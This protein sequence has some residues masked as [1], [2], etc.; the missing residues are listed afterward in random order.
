M[1]SYAQKGLTVHHIEIKGFE[2]VPTTLKVNKGDKVVWVNKDSIPHNIVNN[3]NNEILSTSLVKGEK[4]S[5]LI[6]EDLNYTCGFHPSMRGNLEV[7]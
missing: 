1:N 3:K 2:F 7:Q 4:F 6:D 5:Y